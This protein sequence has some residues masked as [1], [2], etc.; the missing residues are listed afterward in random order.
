MGVG[1]GFGAACNAG[2]Q[3]VAMSLNAFWA[4][5]IFW[6]SLTGSTAWNRAASF[7]LTVGS[8]AG[9]AMSRSHGVAGGVVHL[10]HAC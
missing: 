4:M 7:S 3:Y 9:W 2:G 10:L 5:R 6:S 1:D 8:T